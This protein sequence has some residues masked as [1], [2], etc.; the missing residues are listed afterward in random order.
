MVC[1]IVLLVAALVY[2][3]FIKKDESQKIVKPL[4]NQQTEN[5][6]DKEDKKEKKA[7][8]G[9]DDVIDAEYEEN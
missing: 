2:F 1:V 5:K 3:V 4:D 9:D 8:K 7:K 6:E